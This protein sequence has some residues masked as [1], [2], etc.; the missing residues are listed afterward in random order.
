MIRWTFRTRQ[1]GALVV[2]DGPRNHEERLRLKR[3]LREFASLS[4]AKIA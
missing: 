4:V 1:T 3:A 2:V